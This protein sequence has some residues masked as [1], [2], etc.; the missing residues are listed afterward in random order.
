MLLSNFIFISTVNNSL[1]LQILLPDEIFP[2]SS[3]KGG[4]KRLKG[5]RVQPLSQHPHSR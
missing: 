5:F 1:S 2:F 4:K 3:G